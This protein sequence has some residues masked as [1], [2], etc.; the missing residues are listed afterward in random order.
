MNVRTGDRLL[1]VHPSDGTADVILFS[2]EGRVIRFPESDIPE[3][4]RAAQ[5][6]RAMKLADGDRI[7]GSALVRRTATLCAISERA[8]GRRLQAEDLATQKRDGRG[9][10]GIRID[11]KAG[12][13]VRALEVVDGDELVLLTPGGTSVPVSTDSIPA[14][15][16]GDPLEKLVAM[17]GGARVA[18]VTRTGG[19]QRNRREGPTEEGAPA[20]EADARAVDGEAAAI[21]VASDQAEE[22]ADAPSNSSGRQFDLLD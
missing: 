11:E 15:S 16:W 17:P 14:G 20:T 22:A 9:M 4:G 18:D 12:R 2:R 3:M 1:W 21:A 7:V 6:V 13:L 19:L 10:I 5:G 8:W